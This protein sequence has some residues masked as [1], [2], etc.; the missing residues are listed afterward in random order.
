MAASE[1]AQPNP[2]TLHRYQRT[3][4]RYT[5][6]LGNGV[7]LPLMLIPAGEFWMGQTEAE[8][9]ELKRQV[10]EDDYESRYTHELPRHRVTVPPFLMGKYPIT[11]AQYTAVMGDN[12]AER[13]DE[14]RFVGSARPVVGITWDYAVVFCKNLAKLTGKGYRLPSEAEWE[15]ACRAETATPFH[16]GPILSTDYA[17]YNGADKDYWVYGPGSRGENRAVTTLVNHFEGANVYGLYVANPQNFQKKVTLH[18]RIRQNFD[19]LIGVITDMITV[20]LQT[21]DD[22]DTN[23]QFTQLLQQLQDRLTS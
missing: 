9:V 16:F 19:E 8:T 5:E 17:N 7:T 10:G 12:P 2:L 15:Y 21:L 20:D 14:Q 13:Y 11:Q 23:P 22:L 18:N 1:N 3:N 6:N 4:K